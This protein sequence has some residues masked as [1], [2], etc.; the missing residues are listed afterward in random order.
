MGDTDDIL[1]WL[2]EAGLAGGQETPAI[3]S[4][5]GGVSSDVF[6]VDLASGPVCV[7]RAL[8][9]L[10]VA[11]DW[12]A[13]VE[14][15]AYEAAYLRT[16]ADL[17]GPIMPRILAEDTNRHLFAMTWFDPADHPVW[18]AELAE[19]RVNAAFARTLGAGIARVHARTAGDPE[20]AG[21]F[22]TTPLF[23]DLRLD[24]YLNHT[25]RA[26][27][28]LTG[29]ILG[30]AE[31]TR[32]HR[33]AL[34]HG[35]VSPK[36]ILV[37]PRGPVL[38]DAECAW[39]GDPAFD[40]AFCANHLL[41]KAVWKPRYADA[42]AAAYDALLEGYLAGIDWEPRASLEAR[43][44]PLLA[45]LL[46]ARVDGKSPVEYL[47][48]SQDKEVVRTA[49][50]SMLKQDAPRFADIRHALYERLEAR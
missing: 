34:V 42:Y 23:E 6:R 30:L 28:D 8:S 33:L 32:T 44:A 18:K 20:I 14:R 37:G 24:P 1:D 47:T 11:A 15:S 31:A 4:L 40:I 38:L 26:Y 21:R 50:V 2:R 22:D 25:A 16:A 49:A 35:D 36:N 13:P 48:D 43:A 12:R 10:K 19:G 9:Q 3:T 41:L 5:S 27:P 7:K 45:S 29:H 17:G 46:L 39:Y